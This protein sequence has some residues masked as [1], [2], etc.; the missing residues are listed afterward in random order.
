MKKLT[1]LLLALSFLLGGCFSQSNMIRHQYQT[2]TE[3]VEALENA[4]ADVPILILDLTGFDSISH[5]ELRDTKDKKFYAYGYS[6]SHGPFTGGINLSSEHD[7]G[8][9]TKSLFAGFEHIDDEFSYKDMLI[10][11]SMYDNSYQNSNAIRYTVSFAFE[12][13]GVYYYGNAYYNKTDLTYEKLSIDSIVAMVKTWYD[14]NILS[15]QVN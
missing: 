7:L 13:K 2:K 4:Y 5:I 9:D 1:V 14:T 12:Y 15:I 8:M 6:I 3:L 10:R 11:T